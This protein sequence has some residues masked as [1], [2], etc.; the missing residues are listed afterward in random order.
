MLTSTRRNM[1]AF[2]S[3]Y[4][5]ESS[6]VESYVLSG[7]KPLVLRWGSV[8]EECRQ[9]GYYSDVDCYKIKTRIRENGYLFRSIREHDV[10][11]AGL[12]RES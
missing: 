10:G 9:P 4:G 8:T 12:W 7:I 11:V 6:T 1:L 2:V 5:S 3:C